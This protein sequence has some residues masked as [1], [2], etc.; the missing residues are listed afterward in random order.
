[1]IARVMAELESDLS[2]IARVM[3]EAGNYRFLLVPDTEDDDEAA[4]LSVSF[5]KCAV[6]DT[7]DP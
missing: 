4:D 7:P 6:A 1:M 2:L 5:K 3:S